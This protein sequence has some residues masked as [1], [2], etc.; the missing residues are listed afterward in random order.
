L[1]VAE[2]LLAVIKAAL[3]TQHGE[4]SI[5][6]E[7]SGY[8]L[9]GNIAWTYDGMM[10]ALPDEEWIFFQTMGLVKLIEILLQL[11]ASVNLSKFRKLIRG[12]KKPTGKRDKYSKHP[13]V[14]TVR[15][16]RGEKPSE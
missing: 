4:E 14:S 15:L 2:N 5:E 10:I 6:K 8:Y 11:A 7:L 9:A 1:L 13:H 16:L 12:P 3:R